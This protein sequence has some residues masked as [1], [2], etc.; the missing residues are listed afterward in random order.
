[1]L[2]SK[3]SYVVKNKKFALSVKGDK[4]II[5]LEQFT[6]KNLNFDDTQTYLCDIIVTDTGKSESFYID[7]QVVSKFCHLSTFLVVYCVCVK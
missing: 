6:I 2:F 4:Y 1:M 7:Y 3:Y 5:S